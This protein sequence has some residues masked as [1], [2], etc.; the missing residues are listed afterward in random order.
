MRIRISVA[1]ATY[2]GARFIREQLESIRSQARMP[3]ELIVCDDRS[4]DGTV[5]LVREFA[6]TCPFPVRIF[7]NESNLGF[8]D[9]FLRCASLCTGEW[10]AFCDQDDVWLRGRLLEAERQISQ[11]GEDLCLVV[12]KAE[13]VDA[14]LV[15]SGR[16]L[17]EFSGSR[18]LGPS[19]MRADWFVGG[20][21]MV[22]RR[23][24]LDGA[25]PSLRPH[26]DYRPRSS[27]RMP[28]DR[29]VCLL[30]NVSGRIAMV[31]E[32]LVLYRRHSAAET[33]AHSSVSLSSTVRAAVAAG[34]ED[35][36]WQSNVAREC[37]A[38]FTRLSGGASSSKRRESLALAGE[39][40]KLY[41]A[42][43]TLRAGLYSKESSR[44]ERLERLGSLVRSG[45][46]WS[47]PPVIQF[48]GKAFLKDCGQAA[49]VVRRLQLWMH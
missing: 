12:S 22:F 1:M 26:D 10:V 30:A 24:L 42:N 20:C 11:G 44:R 29:W 6:A 27:R 21:V 5:D 33:G 13:V 32:T 25:E 38:E 43:L 45:A 18:V 31:D 9:N 16:T 3:D 39:R 46:Y 37:A 36:S 7:E 17:P 41:A 48:G 23:S 28:H 2:N 34:Y 8:A 40:F 49:G 47:G 4:T 15:R 14:A 19:S 35:Y